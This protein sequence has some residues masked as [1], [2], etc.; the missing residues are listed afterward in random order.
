MYR[1][2]IWILFLVA[3]TVALQ[4]PVPTP[5]V[6]PG[7]ELIKEHPT[8]FS[9]SVH[10]AAYAFLTVLAAWTP[11]PSRYRWLLM[12][13][14]MGHASATELLQAEL[15]DYCHR[16]GTL[17]D[18]GLDHLAIL[19]GAIVSWKWWTRPDRANLTPPA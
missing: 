6:L 9:K 17:E 16:N 3:W 8:L 19:L 13:L 2:L 18:V 15:K 5:G 12:F 11:A 7:G 4:V 14:L 10:V 1:W